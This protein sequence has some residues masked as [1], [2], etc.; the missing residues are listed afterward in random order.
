MAAQIRLEEA[1]FAV[2][3]TGRF[4]SSMKTA[5]LKYQAQNGHTADGI[6]G[7]YTWNTLLEGQG[8]DGGSD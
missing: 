8:D 1:G 2:P 4:D 7:S 3:P 5:V 6:I